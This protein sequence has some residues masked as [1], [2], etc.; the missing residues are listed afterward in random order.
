MN[1]NGFTKDDGVEESWLKIKANILNTAKK[2][3][4]E[5]TVN[6]NKKF[7]KKTL[8]FCKEVKKTVKKRKKHIWNA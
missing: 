7:Q 3:F 8:Q 1:N 6:R 4:G 5:E 2:Y